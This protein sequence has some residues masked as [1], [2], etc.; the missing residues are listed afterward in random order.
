M[1]RTVKDVVPTLR[2]NQDG[3]KKVLD[4]LVKQYKLKQ[5]ELDNWKVCRGAKL[6]SPRIAALLLLPVVY[7]CACMSSN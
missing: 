5:E 6:Y 4:D 2:T 3:L 1:E 7:M